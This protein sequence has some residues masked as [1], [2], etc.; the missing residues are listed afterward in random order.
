MAKLSID[1]TLSQAKSLEKRGKITEAQKLYQDILQ[2]FPKNRRA[3]QSLMILNKKPLVVNT[4]NPPQEVIDQLISDFNSGRLSIVLTLAT[5]LTNQFP[6]SF[7]IW[8]ILG[9]AAAQI[10]NLDQA[11]LAFQKVILLKPNYADA[12]N[13]LGNVLKDQAKY[14]FATEAYDKAL[15]LHPNFAEALNNKGLV[16]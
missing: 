8:N 15:S 2:A 14:D 12:Y 11:I 13:N 6:A 16:L 4:Q 9:A 1:K 3:R 5:A 7:V 10:G